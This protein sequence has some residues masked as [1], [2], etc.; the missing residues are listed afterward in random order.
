MNAIILQKCIKELSEQI[1]RLDYVRGMLETLAAMLPQTQMAAGTNIIPSGQTA[2][3]TPHN[4][5]NS[6]E[7][8]VP[9]GNLEAIKKMATGV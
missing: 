1:P 9:G 7:A 8:G 4:I 2:P 6:A 5:F 3:F